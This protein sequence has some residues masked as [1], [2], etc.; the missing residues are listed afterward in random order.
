MIWYEGALIS[1]SKECAQDENLQFMA[2]NSRLFE[3]AYSHLNDRYRL[4]S[5]SLNLDAFDGPA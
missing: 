1:S 2:S 5:S 3:L 4:Q